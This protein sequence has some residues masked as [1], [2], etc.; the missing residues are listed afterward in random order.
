MLAVGSPT[1]PTSAPALP[2]I[3]VPHSHHGEP[4][5][6]SSKTSVCP[7]HWE[8]A[9]NPSLYEYVWYPIVA[10]A[11]AGIMNSDPSTVMVVRTVMNFG[12]PPR[13]PSLLL[14]VTSAYVQR[15][16]TA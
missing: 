3:Y 4:V 15:R 1:Q 13:I 10:V 8:Q 16:S 14:R 9:S 2:P 6:T 11:V 7:I 12:R 5:Q